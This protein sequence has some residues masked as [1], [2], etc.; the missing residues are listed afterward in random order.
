MPFWRPEP[1][2]SRIDRDGNPLSSNSVRIG[3]NASWRMYAS[4][5]FMRSSP[6]GLAGYRGADGWRGAH[7]LFRRAAELDPRRVLG[8]GDEL[9][10]VP[11]HP[12]LGDVEARILLLR[13]HPQADRLLDQEEDPVGDG[14]HAGEGDAHAQRLGAELVE[15]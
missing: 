5:F 10:R 6:L 14:E 11:V 4:T 1:L 7:G 9:L 12:V 13:R 15:G 2:A 8:L 3:S